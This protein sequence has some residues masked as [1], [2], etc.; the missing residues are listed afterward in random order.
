MTQTLKLL[1]PPGTGKTHRLLELLALELTRVDPHR[2]AFLT[3]TR[4]ARKEALDR[5]GKLQT[6]LPWV[7]TLHSVCYQLLGMDQERMVK[8]SHLQQFG[9][10]IGEKITG[11]LLDPWLQEELGQ[12]WKPPTRN[13]ELLRLNHLGRHRQIHLREAL[14]ETSHDWQ[15]AR[16]FTQAYH[17]WKQHE[18]LLDYT[19]LLSRYLL[20]GKPLD[21]DVLF[22]DEAQDLSKLQWLVAHKLGARAQRMYLAGDDD[23]AI[24]EWAGA[25]ADQLMQEPAD[26]LEVLPQSYRLPRAVYQLAQA[27]AG[28]LSH[29]VLKNYRPR[30]EFGSVDHLGQ[31]TQE[32]L[33]GSTF[34]LFRNHHRGPQL[35][36]KLERLLVPFHG[37]GTLLS[38]EDVR[39][40]LTGWWWGT[41]G[42]VLTWE[43]A[44]ALLKFTPEDQQRVKRVPKEGKLL[45]SDLILRYPAAGTFTHW[46]EVLKKLPK[47]DWLSQVAERHGFE[48]LLKP[49][50]ELMSMHQAKGRQADTVVL[51]TEMAQRTWEGFHRQPD[52]EHRVFY[53]GI[54]RARERVLILLPEDPKHYSLRC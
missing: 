29:R 8:R 37:P 33:H 34:L 18:C 12:S 10:L 11:N 16:W 38:D 43:Q 1:G 50:I 19:D 31:L 4:A 41:Q 49:R 2:I 53:V 47:L 24:F 52:Q 26:E 42:K 51:D 20:E 14:F 40:A 30:D 23:Q 21:I 46:P 17:D 9:T 7:R 36:K 32:D 6:E 5:T 22:I 28:R 27:V 44:R 48:A 25:S 35:Q 3:F 13:D 54:T 39:L 45:I 15:Y